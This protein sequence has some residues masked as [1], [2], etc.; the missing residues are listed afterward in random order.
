MRS[1]SI[2]DMKSISSCT[3]SLYKKNSKPKIIKS[4]R[5]SEMPKISK[6]G[7]SLSNSKGFWKWIGPKPEYLD[8][9]FFCV[10]SSVS[11]L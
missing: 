3:C 5:Y 6:T 7:C 10:F 11:L 2:N 4:S 1:N 9:L 8:D